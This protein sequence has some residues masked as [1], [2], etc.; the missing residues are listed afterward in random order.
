MR[1]EFCR[2]AVNTCMAKGRRTQIIAVVDVIMFVE[3]GISC[4]IFLSVFTAYP[5]IFKSVTF[6]DMVL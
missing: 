6:Q 5:P 3:R 4:V 1:V 2:S